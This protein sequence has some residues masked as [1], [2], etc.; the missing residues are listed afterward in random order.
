MLELSVFNF[1][2]LFLEYFVGALA[3]IFATILTIHRLKVNYVSVSLAMFGLSI[4]VWDILVFLHRT[5]ETYEYS[6]QVFKVIGILHP[7]ILGFF[8]LT[9][10]NIW[11][12][13][14]LNVLCL[15]PSLFGSVL[16]AIFVEY[17]MIRGDFGWSYQ[18]II[19]PQANLIITFFI[20]IYMAS[21]LIVLFFLWLKAA[22]KS[23]KRKIMYILVSFIVFQAVGVTVTNIIFMQSDPNFPP[24]GGL[25]Y[26]ATFTIIYYVSS[27]PEKEVLTLVPIG[28]SKMSEDFSRLVK[29]FIECLSRFPEQLGIRYFRLVSYLDEGG[30]SDL[31]SYDDKGSRIILNIREDVDVNK[32]NSFI[33]LALT[34]LEDGEVERKFNHVLAE[35]ID[36]NYS[37]LGAE[38]VQVLKR[39]EPY[40]VSERVFERFSAS[41]LRQIFLPKGFSE[42]DLDVFSRKIGINHNIL[43]M[44][45]VL[46]EFD[47]ENYLPK[48]NDFVRECLSNNESVYIFTRR[49]SAMEARFK[50]YD[51]VKF[52]F[53]SP[54][55]SKVVK[56]NEKMYMVPVND[57][58]SILGVFNTLC[59]GVS[60]IVFDNLS[61]IILLTSFEQAYKMV[62]HALDIFS[63]TGSHSLFLI[64]KNVHGTEVLSAFESLF[65]YV[66][67]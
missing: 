15:I 18:T 24:L 20:P 40:I 14:M 1:I 30:L 5:A 57:I 42:N 11:K 3:V 27:T 17:S 61:D 65:K 64:N 12:P 67:K 8:F 16:Y 39:H 52:F 25:F 58:S 51:G 13:R 2:F 28:Y 31:I 32:I 36:R 44:S 49:G 38:L 34:L 60:G 46:I 50:E 23:L 9:F 47:S 59:K 6:L 48:V 62:R 45:N 55:S 4:A 22:T 29:S 21:V 41:V 54:T 33:D 56:L 53:L 19:D 43:R 37:L 35:F 10:L 63:G 26:L 66:I 7:F